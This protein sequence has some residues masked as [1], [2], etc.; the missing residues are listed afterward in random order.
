MNALAIECGRARGA[1]L[2]W[3][4]IKIFGGWGGI[5][6]VFAGGG[7]RIL[8]GHFAMGFDQY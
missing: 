3:V 8:F 4:M 7:G 2:R 6:V 5:N 1:S